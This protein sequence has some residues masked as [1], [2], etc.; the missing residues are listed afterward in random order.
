MKASLPPIPVLYR[1]LV[2]LLGIA[3]SLEA[4]VVVRAAAKQSGHP[5]EAHAS[6]T[7]DIL[8]ILILQPLGF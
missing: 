4:L 5:S 1:P 7:E 8:S 6:V 2:G 3:S